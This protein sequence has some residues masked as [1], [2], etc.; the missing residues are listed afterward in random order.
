MA[1]VFSAVKT[2]VLLPPKDDVFSLFDSAG[3]ELSDG[4]VLCIASKCLAIHQGRCVPVGVADRKKLMVDEADEVIRDD[5]DLT[6]KDGAIIAYSGIDESNGNGHYILWP[7]NVGEL[8]GDIHRF[9]C[10]K[11]SVDRLGIISVDSRLE[12]MRW[13]TVGIS[14]GI[15]GFNPVRDCRGNLDIFGRPLQITT[16]N[17]ADSIACTACHLMGEGAEC[18]PL[19]VVSG[20]EGI[21]FGSDFSMENLKISRKADLFSPIFAFQNQF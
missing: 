3:F 18:R 7:A 10:A 9:L 4:D 8:L 5:C 19:V 15:F 16:M 13:G 1:L 6:V 21:E 17:I 14:Q 2:R 11:F 20:L 12:P